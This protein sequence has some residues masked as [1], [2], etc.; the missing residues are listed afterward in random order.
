[1]T[2]IIIE[3][4]GGVINRITPPIDADVHILVRDYD[5]DGVDDTELDTDDEGAQ[6][7]E[8]EI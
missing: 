5:T 1:M 3:V 6:Y 4:R 2:D 7:L 8:Y